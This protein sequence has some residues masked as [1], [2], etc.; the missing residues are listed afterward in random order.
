MGMMVASELSYKKKILSHKDFIQIRRHYADLNLP[1]NIKSKFKKNDIKKI[2]YF[3][4]K[5]KKNLDSKINLILLSKIGKTTKPN[6]FFL[7]GSEIGNFLN[8]LII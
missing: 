4:K 5:D 1:L 2:I 6:E 8:S 3:M 7:K